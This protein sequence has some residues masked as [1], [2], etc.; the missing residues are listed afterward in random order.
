MI[1]S[2]SI[3]QLHNREGRTIVQE[4]LGGLAYINRKGVFRRVKKPAKILLLTHE[5]IYVKLADFGHSGEAANQHHTVCGTERCAAP[6]IWNALYT[7]NIDM[8]SLGITAMEL[9]VG[10]PKYDRRED[11]QG[12]DTFTPRHNSSHL[13]KDFSITC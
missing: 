12:K 6:E 8:W 4:T 9:W 10:L 7:E 13:V 3:A 5:L 11:T 2:E 1:L